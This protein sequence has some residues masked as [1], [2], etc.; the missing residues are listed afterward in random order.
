MAHVAASDVLVAWT[1]HVESTIKSLSAMVRFVSLKCLNI[2][3]RR[4]LFT[5]RGGL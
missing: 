2:E 3:N 5:E 4:N 1:Q